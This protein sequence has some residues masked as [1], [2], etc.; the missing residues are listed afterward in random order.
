MY[1]QQSTKPFRLSIYI[2]DITYSVPYG[3]CTVFQINKI[4]S[5]IEIRLS[6]QKRSYRCSNWANIISKTL[7]NPFRSS[8]EAIHPV[9]LFHFT[10][11]FLS[12]VLLC[13]S[14]FLSC[15][16]SSYYNYNKNWLGT[17]PWTVE[18]KKLQAILMIDQSAKRMSRFEPKR[19]SLKSGT[20]DL[21]WWLSIAVSMR[22]ELALQ[23]FVFVIVVIV[24]KN[25]VCQNT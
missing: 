9:C 18:M 13:L 12:I 14:T 7:I 23:V 11:Y 17:V 10:F 20:T 16:S 24:I 1:D 19:M 21:P 15:W 4:P 22:M 5:K 6:L 2:D 3:F 8:E 25:L